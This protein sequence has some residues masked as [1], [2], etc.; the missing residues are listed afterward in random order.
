MNKEIK[1]INDK[2]I[3][4]DENGKKSERDLV[5]NIEE[6]LV[7][8]NNIEEIEKKDEILSF[9]YNSTISNNK[10]IKIMSLLGYSIAAIFLILTTM[11][12]PNFALIAGINALMFAGGASGAF[13]SLNINKNYLKK[14]ERQQKVLN[15]NLEQEKTKL[16]NL[17]RVSKKM[18]PTIEPITKEIKSSE[19]IK[20]LEQKLKIIKNYNDN[21]KVYIN[22]FYTGTLNQKLK[23]MEYTA[24]DIELINELINIDLQEKEQKKN[25]IQKR[26]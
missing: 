1:Y 16:E 7:V 8:E 25:G 13:I 3:I 9:D 17:K 10:L 26:K 11:L 5:D 14:L 4:K 2:V 21:R 6:I 15:K 19:M 23:E 22:Y 24:S 18:Q 12:S 20:N